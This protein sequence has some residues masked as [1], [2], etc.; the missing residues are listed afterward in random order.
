MKKLLLQVLFLMLM[1]PMLAQTVVHING[2]VTDTANSNPIPNHAVYILSDSSYGYTYYNTV[3]TGPTGYYGDTIPVPTGSSG[4]FYVYTFDCNNLI[5]QELLT[6]NPANLY[7][8]QDFSI[9]N[10]NVPCQAAFTA[11]PDSSNATPLYFL[12]F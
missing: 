3:Y 8:T 2:T 9:C 10:S 1:V 11:L 6:F 4:V 5:H 7:L 12:F